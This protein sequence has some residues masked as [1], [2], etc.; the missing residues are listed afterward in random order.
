MNVQTS[1]KEKVK[2]MK[3]TTNKV[4]C[5]GLSKTGT[6]SVCKALEL[7]GLKSAHYVGVEEFDEYDVVG[8]S[9]VPVVYKILDEKHPGSKF[10]LTTRD[11]EKWVN[12][13][14]KHFERWSIEEK[15]L[16]G[17]ARADSVLT[18]YQLY[19]TVLF[20]RDKMLAGFHR[21]HED[22][23]EYFSDRP[24][25]L[26]VI[27]ITREAGWEEICD[28]LSL[29]VPENI[30]FPKSNTATQVEQYLKWAKSPLG[31]AT[32]Y[33]THKIKRIKELVQRQS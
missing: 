22:L 20:D 8:D 4:F 27:D 6:V 17:T 10:I 26:L 7:L 19:G 1:L 3:P 5:L 28:F 2:H 24:D 18:R 14:E 33:A 9:P 13:F 23:Y 11:P 21:Y 16:S 12:S 32:S 25:D 31:R 29:S 15:T 30:S